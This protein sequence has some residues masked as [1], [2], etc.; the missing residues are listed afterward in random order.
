MLVVL[1]V[2][3]VVGIYVIFRLLRAPAAEV[4][5]ELRR[6]EQARDGNQNRER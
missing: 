4:A 1:L 5:A 6:Q 3:V 2:A